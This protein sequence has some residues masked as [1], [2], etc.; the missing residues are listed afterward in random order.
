MKEETCLMHGGSFSICLHLVPTNT[1]LTFC[2]VWT[3]AKVRQA[4]VNQPIK[5]PRNGRFSVK[6]IWPKEWGNCYH[7]ASSTWEA[8]GLRREKGKRHEGQTAV[9]PLGQL[10]CASRRKIATRAGVLIF[11]C[12]ANV[13]MIPILHIWEGAAAQGQNT[14]LACTGPSSIPCI[15]SSSF[16]GGRWW[17]TVAWWRFGK[18]LQLTADKTDLDEPV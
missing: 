17:E 15:C 14:C 13:Y 10:K 5:M 6:I 11:V 1:C 8:T 18:L 16:L 7:P 12:L 3:L 9:C 4:C 2:H